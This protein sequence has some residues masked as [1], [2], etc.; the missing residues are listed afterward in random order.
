MFLIPWY[1]LF[2]GGQSRGYSLLECLLV[3]AIAVVVT[4]MAVHTGRGWLTDWQL[5]H[6]VLVLHR[7]INQVR[8]AALS[9]ASKRCLCLINLLGR[10]D[11]SWQGH[12][13]VMVDAQG[14]VLQYW[15]WPEELFLSWRGNFAR[16]EAVCFLPSGLTDGQKG[17]FTVSIHGQSKVIIIGGHGNI[18]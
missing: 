4:T 6:G 16:N 11:S 5:R 10:C 18:I 15:L 7:G 3:M 17:R 14:V 13:M 9:H 8:L 2:K 1:S 12:H